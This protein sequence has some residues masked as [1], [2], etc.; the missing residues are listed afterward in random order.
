MYQ[1]N[2]AHTVLEMMRKGMSP[3]EAAIEGCKRV[4]A[5]YNNNT[6]KLKKFNINFYALN[7]SGEHGAASLFGFSKTLRVSASAL[8]TPCTTER[9]TQLRD[10]ATC[11]K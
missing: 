10:T 7:K 8:S 9:Q 2:G 6:A 4:A 3:T 1:I 11:T 5:N